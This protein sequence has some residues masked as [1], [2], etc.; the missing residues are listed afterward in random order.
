MLI[1][2]TLKNKLID[3]LTSRTT[4]TASPVLSSYPTYGGYMKLHGYGP[5]QIALTTTVTA[6]GTYSFVNAAYWNWAAAANGICALTAPYVL[7]KTASPG[8]IAFLRVQDDNLSTGVLDLTCSL[9]GGGGEVILSSLNASN[10]PRIDAMSF[11]LPLTDNANIWFSD[12]V[13]N[14]ILDKFLGTG[15]TLD[16]GNAGII[17]AYTG[18]PPANC[19]I[20]ATGTKLCQWNLPASTTNW[21][22]ASAGSATLSASLTS[23]A[24]L[25]SGTFGYARW[26]K[27]GKVI[28]GTIGTTGTAFLTDSSVTVQGATSLL[29]AA[30]I[31]I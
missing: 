10:N 25:A 6:M 7:T 5:A 18:L 13:V 15:T 31:A 16:M 2:V 26:S 1:N 23:A 14:G 29:V 27:S 8:T 12:S 21:N 3:D 4:A 19:G 24:A 30:S 17:E 22:A 20:P 28:Q 9:A 11:K